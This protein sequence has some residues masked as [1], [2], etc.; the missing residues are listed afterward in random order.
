[1][2]VG[3]RLCLRLVA[4]HVMPSALP[5]EPRHEAFGGAHHGRKAAVRTERIERLQCH[6]PPPFL[7]NVASSPRPP[8]SRSGAF[9]WRRLGAFPSLRLRRT[10]HPGHPARL[11][12]C[13]MR[14]WH[15]SSRAPSARL[16]R[17]RVL[18]YCLT[19]FAWG[20]DARLSLTDGVPGAAG[21]ASSFHR[22]SSYGAAGP[23][24]SFSRSTASCVPICI[25]SLE[26]GAS[27][28]S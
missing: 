4:R 16:S 9:R 2:G 8:A 24:I 5:A 15:R 1:L 3:G 12:G 23:T 6:V 11:P 28:N 19:G 26:S 17:L 20:L 14:A 7:T 22:N 10:R 27:M 25:M 13:A 21:S 18:P